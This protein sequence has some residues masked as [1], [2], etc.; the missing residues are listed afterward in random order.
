MTHYAYTD[1]WKSGLHGIKSRRTFRVWSFDAYLPTHS[2]KQHP[3]FLA[4]SMLYILYL[5]TRNKQVI[6]TP[7]NQIYQQYCTVGLLCWNFPYSSEIYCYAVYVLVNVNPRGACES[8]GV[9]QGNPGDLDKVLTTHP[10]DFDL[11]FLQGCLVGVIL[12][13]INSKYPLRV[14]TRTFRHWNEGRDSDS[15]YLGLS[16]PWVCWGDPHWLVH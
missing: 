8:L 13:I 14:A 4:N 7:A 3:L 2:Y 9:F 6:L 15:Q 10:G 16:V 1:K 12:D 5:P 11:I